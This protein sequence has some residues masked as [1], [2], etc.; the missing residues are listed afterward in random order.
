[1]ELMFVDNLDLARELEDFCTAV[2]AQKCWR[3]NG[4]YRNMFIELS[5]RFLSCPDSVLDSEGV[6]LPILILV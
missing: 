1:M 6:F 4:A 2:P 3:N 5:V